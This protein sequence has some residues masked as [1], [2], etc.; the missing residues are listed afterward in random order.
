[1]IIVKNIVKTFIWVVVP[2][3]MTSAQVYA[4]YEPAHEQVHGAGVGLCR[5]AQVQRDGKA[6][7]A[8]QQ[9]NTKLAL[10]EY[11]Y[12]LDK[13]DKRIHEL[14]NEEKYLEQIDSSSYE[15]LRKIHYEINFPHDHFVPSDQMILMLNDMAKKYTSF[16]NKYS[17]IAKDINDYITGK[18]TA[19][20]DTG[21]NTECIKI[22][23]ERPFNFEVL[24]EEA[25]FKKGMPLFAF[26]IYAARV[27]RVA[28]NHGDH[29]GTRLEKSCAISRGYIKSWFIAKGIPER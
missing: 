18:M 24:N 23:I 16:Q 22:P 13:Q 9:Q 29:Y 3:I 25:V 6:R 21:I 10:L 2:C 17:A 7:S 14:I 26:R 12:F 11:S 1:M 27:L 19:L 5:G 28:I 8:V 20:E 4:Y 15:L